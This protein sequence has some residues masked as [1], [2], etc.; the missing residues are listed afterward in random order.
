MTAVDLFFV[1]GGGRNLAE[2]AALGL[3]RGSQNVPRRSLNVLFL[4]YQKS[5]ILQDAAVLDGTYLQ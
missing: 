2:I 1:Q 4:A 3:V 5:S